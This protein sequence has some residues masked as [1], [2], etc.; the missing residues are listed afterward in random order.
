MRQI[1]TIAFFI[2]SVTAIAQPIALVAD[3]LI[4][5]RSD[6]A[7][8][9]AVVLIEHDRIKAVGNAEAIPDGATVIDPGDVTLMPGMI[10]AHGHPL[11]NKDDYQYAHIVQSSAYQAMVAAAALQELMLQGW[12]GHRIVGDG[13]I[14]HAAVDLKRAI[15][16][17]VIVGPHLAVASHYLSITGGGG[18]MNFV[19][20][21]Q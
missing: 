3:R 17:G 9:D 11:M 12:T 18:D 10:D 6:V 7:L 16:E 19:S 15:D 5:G 1:S 2:I 14:F 8:D 21:E 20:P 4:D 13:D